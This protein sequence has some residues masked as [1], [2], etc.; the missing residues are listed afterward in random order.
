MVATC[1][2]RVGYREAGHEKLSGTH[3]R[4]LQ[5]ATYLKWSVAWGWLVAVVMLVLSLPLMAGLVLLVRLTSRGPGIYRQRRVGLNGRVFTIYKLRTMYIDAEAKT[6][7]VWATEDDPRI[8][9][10]GRV[11]RRTHLDELPQLFN[12]LQGDMGLIGPRPE[13]PEFTDKL[14]LEIRGFRNRLVCRPGITG[15]AQVCLP[16][17]SDLAGVQR[18][19]E[20]DL[21]YLSEATLWLDLQIL[22]RTALRLVGN[23]RPIQLSH[24]PTVADSVN[25]PAPSATASPYV[26]A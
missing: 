13:R 12:V 7:P 19:L 2:Q 3:R 25:S 10:V 8:T 22:W 5:A 9:P 14:A 20:L 15:L 16:S 17:D 21:R 23:R 4:K 18:K 1:G 6:G 11:L 24:K 26:A